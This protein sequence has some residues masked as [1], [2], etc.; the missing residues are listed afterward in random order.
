M[1]DALLLLLPGVPLAAS[2]LSALVHQRW[3]D[4]TLLLLVPMFVGLAGVWLLVTHRTEPVIGHAVGGFVDGIAI[5]FASDTLS[6]LMLVVCSFAALVCAWFLMVTGEDQYRFVPA[7]V[8]MML[9][10]VYGSILTADLFNLFVFVEVMVLPSYALIAVTGTWRRLG[11]GRMFVIVNLTTSTILLI[12]VGYVY[13]TLGTV[14]IAVLAQM[15][16]DGLL[17]PD[18]ALALGVVLTAF[19]VKAGAAPVH[20]WL[21]RSYPFTSAGMMATFSGLLT[22]V[23]LYAFYRTYVTIFGDEAP[24]T[25]VLLVIVVVTILV[26]ALSCFGEARVRN[27][28]ALQMT[29]GVGHILIGVVLVSA[30]ALQAGIFYMLHHI[31]TMAGLLLTIGAVEQVYGTGSYRK[32]SGLV[33]RE[34]WAAVLMVLG[35]FSLVGLPPTSGLWGKIGLMTA[36]SATGGLVGWTVLGVV[37]IGSIITL[38]ALQRLWSNTFWGAPMKT[39]HPDSAV[40]GRQPAT[41]LPDDVRVP[42]RLLLPGTVMIGLSVGLF[43]WAEP[44]MALSGDA[45]TSLLDSAPYI[46][47]VL[48]S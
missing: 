15:R 44:L 23:G 7:L 5:A 47:A 13:A 9:A 43:L 2:G 17:G 1:N 3:L 6:A 14:N 12:G 21:V 11:V 42:V 18:G 34:K 48:G 37:V 31:L 40:M 28:L 41:T 26:A 29:S 24:F 36:A 35:L 4:R 46:E 20:G 10:G 19:L 8:L 45:A 38:L 27:V 33:A 22:K 32:L 39:Y 25:S 30:A 16:T